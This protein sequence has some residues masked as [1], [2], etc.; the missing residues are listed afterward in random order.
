[1]AFINPFADG[2][3]KRKKK[4]VTPIPQTHKG[5]NVPRNPNIPLATG[6]FSKK[7]PPPNFI[8]PSDWN[9]TIRK[10]QHNIPLQ[11]PTGEKNRVYENYQNMM[12]LQAPKVDPYNSRYQGN[13][14]SVLDDLL[15]SKFEYSVDTDPLYQQYKQMYNR[16]G[17]RAYE[18]ALGEASNMTGGRTN[19]FAMGAAQQ[20][21]NYYSTQLNDKVPELYQAA[22]ARYAQG[23]SDK[24]ANIG[25]MSGLDQVDY[26]R[27]MD[28]VSYDRGVYESDRNFYNQNYLQDRD[29]NYNAY[30]DDRNFNY[31]KERDLV[32]DSQWR[33]QFD[34][35]KERDKVGDSQWL[36]QFNQNAF[37]SNRNY[38]LSRE[39][40]DYDKQQ[41]SEK[42]KQTQ[43]QADNLGALYQGM[44][45]SDDPHS[46][47]VT[48]A[49]HLSEDEINELY[50]K[51][52]KA[53]TSQDLYY[54]AMLKDLLNKNK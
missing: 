27:Y 29:F 53:A 23:L 32:G 50:K 39:K 20:A 7:N 5:P 36:K 4:E 26:G 45:E 19:T 46:W 18:N 48:Y 31:G 34:Y 44:M 22:Y 41:D 54:D 51:L 35:G 25:T 1:M 24:R 40:F 9:E 16:E 13:I 42:K 43:D 3:I 47:L 14:D 10:A 21:Q 12:N 49:P 2:N 17:D 38:G 33:E 52:P 37:E 30:M 8:K 11:I 15:N 28:K 6:G